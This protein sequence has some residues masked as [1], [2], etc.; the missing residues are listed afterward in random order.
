MAVETSLI[1]LL[2]I[3]FAGLAIPELFRKVRMP[4]VTSIILIGA[5]LGPHGLKYVEFDPI[6]AFI[7]F[8]GMTFL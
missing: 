7:G 2:V 6:V 5:I 8:L 1:I 3:L 4:F